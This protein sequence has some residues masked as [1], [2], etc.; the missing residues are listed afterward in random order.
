MN[1][2][3]RQRVIAR[4]AAKW[5]LPSTATELAL[6]N[7]ALRLAAL[8]GAHRLVRTMLEPLI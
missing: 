2:V 7:G 6:R 5:L 3:A 1:A 8:S 4:R